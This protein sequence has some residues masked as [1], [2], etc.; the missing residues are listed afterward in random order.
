MFTKT[1]L[2]AALV[3]SSLFLTNLASAA[4]TVT[5]APSAL[6]GAQNL[7]LSA[8]ANFQAVGF[9]SNLSSVLTIAGNSGV[10]SFSETGTI[11][12]TS[13]MNSSNA[14]VSSGV[15]SNYRILGNFS[16]SGFGSWAGNLYTA[17]PAGMSFIVNLIGDPGALGG[18]T[19]NLGSATLVPGSSIAF[20][21]AFG[22]IAP[23]A[24]GSAL[25]SLSANLNFTPGPDTNGVGGFFVAPD[26]LNLLISVG[27]AGG[28]ATNTGYQVSSTGVVT[29]TNP[30]PG[31]NSGT[32]NATF[33]HKVPEPGAL[34]LAAIALLGVAY[35]SKRKKVASV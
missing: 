22:S 33:V 6:N 28:N 17:S 19:I 4:S 10:Q 23:N 12:V 14:M 7:A 13:F 21:V 5:F 18:P 8:D 31:A 35:A 3:T 15:F 27:N 9:Q 16:L 24:S 32:A 34:S 26:P 11:D 2:S 25:T 29:I 30:I 1:L 20:A